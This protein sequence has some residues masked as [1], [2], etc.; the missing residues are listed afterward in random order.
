VGRLHRV[1]AALGRHWARSAAALLAAILVGC[2]PA[3]TSAGSPPSEARA[4]ALLD[5]IVAAARRADFE[6]LCGFG[7]ANCTDVLEMAGRDRLPQLPPVVAGS[8]LLPPRDGREGGIVLQLCGV[9][10]AGAAY[11]TE[12][13]VQPGRGRL[14]AI[15][16]VYWSGLRVPRDGLVGDDG[17]PD[18]PGCPHQ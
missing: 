3:G 4:R 16:P 7:D 13:L 8:W 18:V 14:I 1:L 5:E 10:A 9:D 11:A 12:M 2:G 6:A 15:Q 17:P